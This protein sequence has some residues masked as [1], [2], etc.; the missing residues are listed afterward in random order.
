MKTCCLFG[1]DLG[2]TDDKGKLISKLRFF[3]NSLVE[4]NYA[5]FILSI[6]SDFDDI[7]LSI[8]QKLHRKFRDIEIILL[9]TNKKDG[10]TVGSICK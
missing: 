2:E 4:K 8:L 5:C 6:N 1:G 3:L 7:A 10:H 9:F